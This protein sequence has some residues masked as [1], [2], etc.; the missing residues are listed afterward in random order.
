L[1]GKAMQRAGR[2]LDQALDGHNLK[3]RHYGVLVVLADRELRTQQEVADLLALDRTTMA[4][5]VDDLEE[6]GLAERR[7]HPSN[8]RAHQLSLTKG[9]REK[10]PALVAAVQAADRG[11]TADLTEAEIDGLRLLLIRLMAR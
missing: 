2:I 7:P 10:L 4:A 9:G 8:R 1:L 5:A 3:G 11:L 6:L